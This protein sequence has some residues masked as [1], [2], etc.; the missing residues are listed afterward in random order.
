MR[1]REEGFDMDTKDGLKAWM[2][3]YCR[4]PN[5]PTRR[6]ICYK[7]VPRCITVSEA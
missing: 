7:K 1:G 4:G 6:H 5:L 3:V 2:R